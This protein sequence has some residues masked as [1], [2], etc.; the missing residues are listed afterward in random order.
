MKK[1]DRREKI[2][3]PLN[4]DVPPRPPNDEIPIPRGIGIGKEEIESLKNVNRLIDEASVEE[5]S[6][7]MDRRFYSMLADE[8]LASE[9]EGRALMKGPWIHD[10]LFRPVL[11]IAAGIALF[12]LGWFTSSWFGHNSINTS[13]MTAISG[14]IRDL[15]ETLVLTMLHQNST[16]ERIKA[17]NMVNEFEDAGSRI[18]E[19]LLSALNNDDNDNVRLLAL[20][21]LLKYADDEAVREGLV[22]SIRNQSSPMIQ[23]RLA[24]VM[25]ALNERRAAPEFQR[26]LTDAGLNYIVRGRINDAVMVLL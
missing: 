22:A 11:R 26:L 7:A 14:E 23:L 25:V 10:L 9:A 12:L 20:D 4:R 15:R 18:K 24:E 17:V 21:A 8:K 1:K 13:Q 16:V 2:F 19:D 5:P 6:P 3:D